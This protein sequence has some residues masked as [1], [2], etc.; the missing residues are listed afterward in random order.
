MSDKVLVAESDAN[1]ADL[2]SEGVVFVD[3]FA[4]WC[5]PCRMMMPRLEEAAIILETEGVDAKIVK[6]DC[7]KCPNTSSAFKVMSIPT[8]VVMKDGKMVSN[9]FGEGFHKHTGTLDVSKIVEVVKK[10]ANA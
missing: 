8:L 6:V 2:T 4:E 3:F 1:F 10:V 7:E 5:G 9:A